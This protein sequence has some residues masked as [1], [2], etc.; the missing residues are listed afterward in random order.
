MN[1]SEWLKT[2]GEFWALVLEVKP[3][4]PNPKEK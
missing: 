2:K 4:K 1:Y 3:V